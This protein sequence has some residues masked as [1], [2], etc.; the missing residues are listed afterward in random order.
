MSDKKEGED[1]SRSLNF[2]GEKE[3]AR[4]DLDETITQPEENGRGHAGQKKQGHR[5]RRGEE[6][7]EERDD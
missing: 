5:R 2:G 4:V 3:P 6:R 7:G 1:V